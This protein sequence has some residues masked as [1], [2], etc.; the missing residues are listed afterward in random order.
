MLL[1]LNV[2]IIYSLIAFF[3]SL[4]FYPLYIQLLQK[5]KAGK[6]IRDES[7]TGDKASIFNK[8]HAHK[9]W[10]PTMGGGLIL[11]I[12][13]LLVLLSICV[14]YM[15]Y[16]T[17]SLFAR[18]ETYIL[19]F[20]LFSMGSL[21]FVDDVLNIKWKRGIKGMTAKMKI[22]WMFLFSAFIS[23]RFYW[24]LGIDY[25]NLRP[26]A[27]EVHLGFWYA[28]I[29]FFLT[30]TIVNAINIT[31]GLDG[32]VGGLM[33]IILGVIGILTFVSQWYLATT[34]IWILLGSVLAFL[35]FNINPAKI[36]MG[37]SWALAFGGII[38]A[39]IYLLNI[40][41]GIIIP[42]S[43]LF[44]IFRAEIGSSFLQIFRKKTFKKKIF[45]VAPFHHA[46]EHAGEPEHSIV[47]KFRVVQG[48]LA[49][50]AILG[51]FYQLQM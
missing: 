26:F 22:L 23:Y 36:F 39:L 21:W 8:M 38:S 15:W 28:L 24:K 17:N 43:I 41:F 31:D 29:T 6:Q 3:L 49:A 20:A 42:F 4:M 34:L 32:L 47:M 19:L 27:G 5:W 7:V 50:I 33:I 40:K 10:T 2:I 35:W 46:L 11:L 18:S 1:K 30:V 25:I 13:L 14:Q 45:S 9:K 16:T 37:D 44:A 12:V 48:L 51:I